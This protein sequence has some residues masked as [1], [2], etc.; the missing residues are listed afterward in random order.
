M[1][2]DDEDYD[3]KLSKLLKIF[4]F[5]KALRLLRVAKF[6]M[7]FNKMVEYLR[8]TDGVVGLLGFF[9]LMMIV[10]LMA[11]WIACLWNLLGNSIEGPNW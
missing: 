1:G 3:D 7:I 6:K 10:I 2:N 11:H 5:F 9:K 4:R 8:L